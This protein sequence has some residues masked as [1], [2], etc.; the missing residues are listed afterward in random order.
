MKLLDRRLG[1]RFGAHFNETKTAR[2]AAAA[3]GGDFGHHHLAG[4]G[5]MFPQLLFGP[6]KRQ[7]S[8]KKFFRFNPGG[9]PGSISIVRTLADGR[10]GGDS[11][12]AGCGSRGAAIVRSSFSAHFLSSRLAFSAYRM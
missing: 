11:T 12:A 4:N 8:D 7:I 5:E 6:I 3:E 9:T 1:F 2:T 10:K